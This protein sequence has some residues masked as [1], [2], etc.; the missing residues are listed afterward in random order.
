MET[1][2]I[3]NFLQMIYKSKL[4][5]NVTLIDKFKDEFM[6]FLLWKSKTKITGCKKKQF[7]RLQTEIRRE[8]FK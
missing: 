8:S 6:Q 5:E 2:D 7:A 4:A 3:K 1:R